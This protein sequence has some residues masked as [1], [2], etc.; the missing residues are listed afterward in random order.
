VTI[1]SFKDRHAG[2]PVALLA[3]G[4]SILNHDLGRITC[5]RIGMNRSW[6]LSWPDYH[7]VLHAEQEMKHPEVYKRLASEGRLFAAGAYFEKFPQCIRIPIVTGTFATDLTEGVV[8]SI[9]GA[10]SVA[11]VAL[12]LAAYMGFAPIYFLGLDLS[13][14]HF[15][16]EW[17]V[18]PL[19]GRQNELFDHTP[20]DLEVWNVGSPDSACRRFLHK[21]FDEVWA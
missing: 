6:E 7:V 10:G 16:R 8:V 20:K 18:S 13:G 2:E 15:H 19:I 11:Y 9:N 14:E 12:Q 1:A 4:A 21:R 3:N 17:N 5:R